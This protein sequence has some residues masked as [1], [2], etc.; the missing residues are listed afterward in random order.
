MI[1]VEITIWKF[2]QVLHQGKFQF[3]NIDEARNYA[4]GLFA[5]MNLMDAG[6]TGYEIEG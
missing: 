5:G 1:T 6:A 2:T 3:Q 4:L